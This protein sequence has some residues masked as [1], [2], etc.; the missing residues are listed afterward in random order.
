MSFS[1]YLNVNFLGRRVSSRTESLVRLD[2]LLDIFPCDF[3][4]P[5]NL[6][7]ES[8][9]DRFAAMDGNYSATTVGV[10]QEVVASLDSDE[11]ETKA[12]KR[13]DELIAVEC[14]KCAHAMTAMR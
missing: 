2:F 13:L 12:T 8:A 1:P 5:E 10:T 14:R 7:E 6:R 3:T 11:V 4:I 9:A